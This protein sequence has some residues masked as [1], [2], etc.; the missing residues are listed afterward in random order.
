[1]V[2]AAE[3]TMRMKQQCPEKEWFD[4]ECKKA[5]KTRNLVYTP[6]NKNQAA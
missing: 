3:N 6:F 5:I 2:K 1:M 4:E